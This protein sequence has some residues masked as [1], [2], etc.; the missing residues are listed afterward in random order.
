MRSVK[1]SIVI[2]IL[3]IAGAFAYFYTLDITSKK[4]TNEINSIQASALSDDWS[5]ANQLLS[6]FKSEF[7]TKGK[8]LSTL[9]DH[10]EIDSISMSLEKLIQYGKFE[11]KPEFMAELSSLSLL[12]EHLPEKEKLN[13]QNF[14]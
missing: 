7:K 5:D 12:I 2:S 14:L 4:L 11:E 9:I 8:V 10:Y 1:T 13:M 3:L 6:D